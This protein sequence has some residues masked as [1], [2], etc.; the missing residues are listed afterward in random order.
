M[1]A[2]SRATIPT[3]ELMRREAI[4][5]KWSKE[6]GFDAA[7]AITLPAAESIKDILG[8]P[9]LDSPSAVIGP[10]RRK[11][12]FDEAWLYWHPLQIPTYDRLMAGLFLWYGGYTGCC[13]LGIQ[14]V[15]RRMGRLV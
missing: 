8:L 9:I 4:L 13:P 15:S 12:P 1:P 14:M 6:G 10:D 2:T 7:S 5:C 11:L 3:G